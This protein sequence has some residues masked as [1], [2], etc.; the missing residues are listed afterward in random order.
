VCF[1]T[2]RVSHIS[3]VIVVEIAEN[4]SDSVV[5]TKANTSNTQ[6][7]VMLVVKAGLSLLNN[8]GMSAKAKIKDPMVKT[9][10]CQAIKG[11]V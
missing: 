1:W 10:S 3:P 9:I 8:E 11:L 5:Y 6:P 2:A 7:V 4:Q